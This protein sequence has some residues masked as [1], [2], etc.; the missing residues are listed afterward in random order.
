[1]KGAHQSDLAKSWDATGVMHMRSRWISINDEIDKK[2]Q[3]QYQS[4]ICYIS[5]IFS[6]CCFAD[7]KSRDT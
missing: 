4:T 6:F 7:P 1:M 5:A 3:V 2:K